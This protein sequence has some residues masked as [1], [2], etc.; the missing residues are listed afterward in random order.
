[1]SRE[2]ELNEEHGL[3]D[4]VVKI[5]RTAKVVKGGRRFGFAALVVV[6]DRRGTVGI[7]YG[8]RKR[9]PWRSRRASRKPRSR[10]IRSP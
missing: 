10:C 2:R 1:V 8:K 9:C 5:Y 4:T 6:G 3:E 7:G